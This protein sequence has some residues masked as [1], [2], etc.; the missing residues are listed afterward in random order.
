MPPEGSDK[1]VGIGK[2]AAH[3][4][5]A[6]GEGCLRQQLFRVGQPVEKQILFWTV[7]GPLFEGMTQIIKTNIELVCYRLS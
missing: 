3:G 6:N 5:L 4:D 7:A 1:A 2:T